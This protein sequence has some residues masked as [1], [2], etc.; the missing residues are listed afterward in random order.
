MASGPTKRAQK[1]KT[2]PPHKGVELE[3]A[4]NARTDLTL[5]CDA[6]NPLFQP[7]ALGARV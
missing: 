7:A 1:I 3:A 5:G 4:V 6:D 2:N